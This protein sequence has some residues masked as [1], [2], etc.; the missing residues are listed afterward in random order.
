MHFSSIHFTELDLLF[1]LDDATPH[2]TSSF[3][4]EAITHCIVPAAC[5]IL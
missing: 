4:N 5:S 2:C 3:H 1:G